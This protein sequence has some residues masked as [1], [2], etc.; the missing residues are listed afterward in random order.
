[1][2]TSSET[3]AAIIA[4]APGADLTAR[5]MFGE[6]ALYCK[7]R[8]VALVCDDT[9]FVKVTPASTEACANSE[10]GYPYPGARPHYRIDEE[11]WQDR[12]WLS[13]LFLKST[14][15]LQPP[16]RKSAKS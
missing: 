2:S 4:A 13:D 12:Q 6:Y 7:G 11:L 16:K 15:Y 9:L 14:E 10:Q 8:V 1:M 3:V 5:K